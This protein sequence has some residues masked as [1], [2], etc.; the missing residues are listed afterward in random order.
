[1]LKAPTRG[2][3]HEYIPAFN[4]TIP[5]AWPQYQFFRV[6]DVLGNRIIDDVTCSHVYR[7]IQYVRDELHVPVKDMVFKAT[8]VTMHVLDMFAERV[9]KHGEA[10]LV[11]QFYKSMHRATASKRAAVDKMLALFEFFLPT[12]YMHDNN[13]GQYYQVL[14]ATPMPGML[15]HA[16]YEEIGEDLPRHQPPKTP[17]CG[18]PMKCFEEM[19]KR[20]NWGGGLACNVCLDVWYPKL[21]LTKGCPLIETLLSAQTCFCGEAETL[22]LV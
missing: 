2:P 4:S 21:L 18:V 5:G 15:F 19:K 1:M 12:M 17:E 22:T 10:W 6:K 13:R 8:R 9:W 11:E 7:I 20:C 14:A 3:F 16:K